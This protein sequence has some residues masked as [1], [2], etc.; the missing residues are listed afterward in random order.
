M[1]RNV[2][3]IVPTFMVNICLFDLFVYNTSIGPTP[4]AEGPNIFK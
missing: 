4:C 3:T 2:F 1:I